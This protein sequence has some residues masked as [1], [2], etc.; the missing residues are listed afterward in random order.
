[1]ITA[2]TIH[3]HSILYSADDR[4]YVLK[5][6]T[7]DHLFAFLVPSQDESQAR[8]LFEKLER[9]IPGNMVYSISTVGEH[10]RILDPLQDGESYNPLDDTEYVVR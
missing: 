8:E 4:H 3:P 5:M 1:M 2:Q 7:G 9:V 10:N 6:T